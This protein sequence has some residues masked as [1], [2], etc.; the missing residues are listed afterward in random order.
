M[1]PAASLAP[2]VAL[3]LLG[4]RTDDGSNKARNVVCTLDSRLQSFTLDMLRHHVLSARAKNMHDGAA[5]V[6]DNASGEILAYAGNIGEQ[7][8]ARFVDGIIAMRQAGSTLK[9][10]IYALAFDRR[11]LT[12]ASLTDDSPVNIPVTGGVYRPKNYDNRFHGMVTARVA[13]ASSLN[14]PAVKAL[15]LIGV[16]SFVETM[17]QLNFRNIRAPEYYGLSIALGSADITLWDLVAAFRALANG[18]VWSPLRLIS[19]EA[20]AAPRRIVS[21]EAAFLI[22]DILSDREGRSRTFSLDSPLSTRYWTAVKTGTSKDMRDNWCVGFSDRYTVGIWAGNFSG[23]PM[24]NVSGVTGAAPVWIDIMNWLHRGESSRQPAPPAGVVRAPVEFEDTAETRLEWFIQGTQTAVVRQTDDRLFPR[25]IYP[26]AGM[27]V[28]L[29]PDIPP[30][31]QK[32]FF[33]AKSDSTNLEWILDGQNLGSSSALT[34]WSP[35][36]GK[37]ILRLLDAQS[38]ELDSVSF[39]VRGNDTIPR[40]SKFEIRDSE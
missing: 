23:D 8:S 4:T 37:H 6:V 19:T 29:D 24:W 26:T 9:P 32:V 34:P 27:I 15:D 25:I 40:D 16:D 12:P 39:E 7:S 20:A 31:D 5:L 11:I 21:P 38:H 35:R 30:E 17:H 22:A 2:H 13:L 14:V 33:E 3:H 18:G 28:A 36:K 1:R 10:L